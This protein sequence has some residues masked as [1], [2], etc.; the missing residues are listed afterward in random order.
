MTQ[1]RPDQF[2][3]Q[4]PSASTHQENWHAKPAADTEAAFSTSES[5]LTTREATQRL[6][7]HGPNVLPAPPPRS[8]LARFAAQFNNLLIYVLLVAA[9]VTVLIG[10]WLDAAVICLV[11]IGNAI[12]GFIQEGRAHR[13]LE[14]IRDMLSQTS[15]AIRDGQRI[16]VPAEDLVPGDVVLLESGDR[17]PADLRLA[18][19]RGAAAEEA[20]LTGESMPV[21]KDTD[22]VDADAPLGDRRCMAYSGTFVTGG[23]ARGIVVATGAETE[24][25]RISG[26]MASIQSLTSPLLR[27]MNDF[28]RVLT[29]AILVM[30]TAV[31]AF[32]YFLRDYSFHDVF[33]IVVG[34]AVAA[35]PEGLPA[36]LTITLA[37]GAQT[38]AGRHAIARSL[39]AIETLGSVSVICTDKTGTLTR[40]EMRV[41]T[42]ATADADSHADE[43]TASPLVAS[44]VRAAALASDAEARLEAGAWRITGDAMEGALLL[45][46][47]EAGLDVSEERATTPRIDTIP[48][49]TRHRFMATLHAEHPQGHDVFMKGAPDKLFQHC[50]SARTP[51][52]DIPFDIDEWTQRL[53]RLADSGQRVLAVCTKRFE[54]PR[55]QVDF[56]DVED[57][58]VLLG[59]VG[60]EDPL[61]P[62]AQAAVEECHAAGI[63][64]KMITGDHLA[65]AR[66][67]AGKLGLEAPHKATE[68]TELDA[69]DGDRDALSDRIHSTG[70]FART[71]PENKLHL[72]EALQAQGRVVAMTG[73]GVNDAPALKR[74]DIGVAMGKKGSEAAKEASDLVL[75]DDNFATIA[76]AVREGRRIYD[77]LTKTILFILPTNGAQSLTII[78]AVLAGTTLPITPLQILWVNLV[79]AV[80]LALAL[81]FEP[82]A[83]NI[84]RRPPRDPSAPVLSPLLVW[85]VVF[86]SVAFLIAVMHMFTATYERTGDDRTARTAATNALVMFEIIY[87]FAL[88]TLGGIRHWR[89]SN[90]LPVPIVIAVGSVILLQLAFTYAPPFNTLFDTA[91]LDMAYWQELA[92]VSVI[93]A[94]A[95]QA[96]FWG[97]RWLARRRLSG[98]KN[99]PGQP[100]A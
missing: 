1:Q 36:V 65:T 74:A 89:L 6:E 87:L 5:G 2:E 70:V 30:S 44:V 97:E 33:L 99:R 35:I 100:V 42:V 22:P 29:G 39:P 8:A 46:A 26:L 13:A 49:D 31:F 20:V 11:V 18:Y 37:L 24:I 40:N 62:E 83:P 12:I 79:T 53:N 82:A 27:A 91:P 25:G 67:I 93:V 56:D 90:I 4:Q 58:L 86:I 88:R 50:A 23:I 61:R 85:R 60:L 69:L 34:I 19:V 55:T 15:I 51:D 72:V 92:V 7:R 43:P 47:A 68:G 52:G 80:T 78:A 17:V 63:R 96:E 21:R 38:M 54:A 73:D 41:A 98:R 81:A 94:L 75:A 95:L 32:A 16:E 9:V 84:M 66:A 76:A 59:L 3:S 71:S 45:A 64:V 14:A 57:G 77:N 10:H 28:A 48:F